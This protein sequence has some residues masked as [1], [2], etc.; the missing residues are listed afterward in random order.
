MTPAGVLETGHQPELPGAERRRHA[1]VLR[2]R[3]R[4]RGRRRRKA[5]SAPSP[6]TAPTGKLKLLNTVRSG[7]A[8]PDL[9]E[10]APVGAV[11]ARGQLLRRL[12]RGAAGSGRR[13]AGRSRPTS[14]TTTGKIG[15]TKATN[16][17]PGSFAFSGHDRTHAHMIQADPSGRFVLHVDLG[18]DKIFVWKF[19]DEEGHADAERS[20]RRRRC[21]P[22]TARGTSTSTP[23]ASWLYSIQEEGSTV[24]LFDYDAASRPAHRRGRRSP[25]CRPGSPAATSA[26]RSWSRPT[27]SSSTPATGCTTASASSPSART[28]TLTYV[29]EEWTRGN[30]PRSFTF[31]PTGEFLYC[32]NQRGDNVTVFR[33]DRKTGGLD[34]HRPLRARRQPVAHRLPRPRRKG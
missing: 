4:P 13:P 11:P 2:Q 31:D 32:C 3:D 28:A 17:P 12:G 16:A 21:R 27:A 1:P 23:T 29:G 26:R 25:R 34:L 24:V 5:R 30:Y 20:A 18:L 8:G 19:D 6:S 9:R 7:G 15:P 10:P 22:A 14:K 33:V